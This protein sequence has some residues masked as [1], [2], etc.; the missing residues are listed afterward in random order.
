LEPMRD[1]N[2]PSEGL[3]QDREKPAITGRPRRPGLGR[4]LDALIPELGSTAPGSSTTTVPVTEIS[5]NPFQPRSELD[6]EQLEELASSIK[7]HGVIQ[8]LLVSESKSRTGHRY[9]LIAGERRWRAAQLAGLS[10][11]PVVIKDA[12][13]QEMLE[14]A[15]I[16]NVMR[17]DLTPLEEAHA[18]RQLIE[19]FQLTQTEI[20]VRV[21]K[22]RVSITNT[23]RLL[24]APAQ[25]HEALQAGRIT[26]GHAR[27]L[28]SLPSGADQIT[29]LESLLEKGWTVRETEAAVRRW[30]E[31]Q[32]DDS[33][34]DQLSGGTRSDLDHRMRYRIERAL[35]TEVRVSRSAKRGNG[36]IQIFFSSEEQLESLVNRLTGED[37][38]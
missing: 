14:L 37:L 31:R 21:G 25:V 29:M 26:E 24:S 38:F 30:F 9:I 4:G 6:E 27:A 13:D 8:P 11:V 1:T 34:Q 17:S 35:E 19:E 7:V 12:T 16:E 10:E 2:A 20:A 36:S 28:L 23:I 15:I 5:V 18:Y 3:G 22:S 33:P 32:Q